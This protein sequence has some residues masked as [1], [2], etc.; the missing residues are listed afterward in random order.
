MSFDH[1]SQKTSMY[2]PPHKTKLQVQRQPPLV[3]DDKS[4]PGLSNDT[5]KTTETENDDNS[6][7]KNKNQMI[8]KDK[9]TIIKQDEEVENKKEDDDLPDG[10]VRFKLDR[11]QKNTLK[12]VKEDHTNLSNTK[13]EKI[14]F[15]SQYLIEF[16]KKR[17]DNYINLYGEDNYKKVF[18]FNGYE[19]NSDNEIS[20][21]EDE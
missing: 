10:W 15:N 17:R 4:F 5:K 13:E 16:F 7:D 1:K 6:L 11:K 3:M 19:Y 2:Q 21:K 12:I 14:I 9:L 18:G 20:A 8:Y